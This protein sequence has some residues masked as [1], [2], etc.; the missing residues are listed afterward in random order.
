MWVCV[1]VCGYVCVC[2]VCVRVRVW[3]V[4]ADLSIDNCESLHLVVH[5]TLKCSVIGV[6][7]V[8]YMCSGVVV[9]CVV[10]W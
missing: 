6:V 9:M 5:W 3:S 4:Y 7:Y 8:L 2:G 1:G 10:V